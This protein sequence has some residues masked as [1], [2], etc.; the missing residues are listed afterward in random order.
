MKLK[1]KFK[2]KE[3][4]K[5]GC[6]H[7]YGFKDGRWECPKRLSPNNPYWDTFKKMAERL[8]IDEINRQRAFVRE[9][10]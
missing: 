2:S 5:L 4:L 3:L 1:S 8:K 9:V 6:I 7:N 10:Y